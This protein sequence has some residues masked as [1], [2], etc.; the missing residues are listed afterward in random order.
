MRLLS[1]A[2]ITYEQQ[3]NEVSSEDERKPKENIK[4]SAHGSIFLLYLWR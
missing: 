3:G 2:V 4:H 1:A